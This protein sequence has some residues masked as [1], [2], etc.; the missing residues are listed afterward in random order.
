MT[1]RQFWSAFFTIAYVVMTGAL[2]AGAYFPVYFFLA[3]TS[4]T[5][6]ILMALLALLAMI[7]GLIGDLF[8]LNP[9][10]EDFSEMKI[11]NS[12][13]R[14]LLG[15]LKNI[16]DDSII[17]SIINVLAVM[18]SAVLMVMIGTPLS[19]AVGVASGVTMAIYMPFIFVLKHYLRDM[20]L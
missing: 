9:T 1:N 4:L 12:S 14:N 20:E 7:M 19:I 2:L 6:L 11:E 8:S 16:K 3:M 10:Y 13:K 5:V 18:T 15:N 17:L